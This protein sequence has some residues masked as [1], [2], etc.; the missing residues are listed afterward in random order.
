MEKKQSFRLK[1][2]ARN[3]KTPAP[4]CNMMFPDTAER[5]IL[6]VQ[7]FYDNV[8]KL[9]Y[10][11]TYGDKRDQVLNMIFVTHFIEGEK[12]TIIFGSQGI[13][14]SAQTSTFSF[15]LEKEKNEFDPQFTFTK[16]FPLKSKVEPT[17][18]VWNTGDLENAW[19]KNLW[20]LI[21]DP[22]KQIFN[23]FNTEKV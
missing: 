14:D 5:V 2:S 19:G 15:H 20:Q 23:N 4:I 11:V 17:V 18:T 22:F 8:Y 9:F 7:W 16:F 13:K 12:V 21:T 3:I 1:K 10:E 6:Y